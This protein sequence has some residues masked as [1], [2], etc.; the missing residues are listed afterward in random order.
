MH[1]GGEGGRPQGLAG[2]AGTGYILSTIFWLPAGRCKR[3]VRLDLF[4][5]Q[6]YLM[7]GSPSAA[8]SRH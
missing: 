5:Y 2:R 4:F 1:T 8:E 7:G 3:P 6:L